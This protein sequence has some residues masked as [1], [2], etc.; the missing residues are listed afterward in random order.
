MCQVAIV[1]EVDGMNNVYIFYVTHVSFIN[2][3]NT[4]VQ[5]NIKFP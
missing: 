4:N 3:L 1:C 2:N 5:L